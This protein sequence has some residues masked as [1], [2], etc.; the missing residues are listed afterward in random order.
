[1]A[2]PSLVADSAFLAL[3]RSRQLLVAPP[4]HIGRGFLMLFPAKV[5]F[6]D[7]RL[8][9]RNAPRQAFLHGTCKQMISL[10]SDQC[11]SVGKGPPPFY[12][13]AV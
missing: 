2:S 9:E 6:A 11:R 5:N 1:M 12:P 8:S 4:R 13:L 10:S 3:R 7:D